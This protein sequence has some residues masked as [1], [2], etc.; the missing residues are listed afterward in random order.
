LESSCPEP[1]TAATLL[2]LSGGDASWTL[3]DQGLP[4]ERV[5]DAIAQ[6]VELVVADFRKRL[7]K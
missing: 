5:P 4:V 6:T 2:S 7:R 1:T 3:V